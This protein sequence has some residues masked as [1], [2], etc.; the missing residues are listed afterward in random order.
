MSPQELAQI[1]N[2]IFTKLVIDEL[3]KQRAEGITDFLLDKYSIDQITR[4]K[5]KKFISEDS[6]NS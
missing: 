1:E 3:K 2:E 5:V 6:Q 4:D